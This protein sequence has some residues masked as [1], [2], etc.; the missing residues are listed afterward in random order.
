[1]EDFESVAKKSMDESLSF[2]I[3]QFK[4]LRVGRPNPYILDRDRKSVV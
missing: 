3:D 4:L 2:L 1:M